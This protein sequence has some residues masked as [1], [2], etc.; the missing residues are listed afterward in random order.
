MARRKSQPPQAPDQVSRT[1]A[2]TFAACCT[3]RAMR[4]MA[5]PRSA[6]AVFAVAIRDHSPVS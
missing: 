3:R 4:W 6:G 1:G 2:V 5:R